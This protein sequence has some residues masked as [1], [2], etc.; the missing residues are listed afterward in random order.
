MS[1]E[2]RHWKFAM[3]RPTQC[4]SG[5]ALLALLLAGCAHPP[6]VPERPDHPFA[7]GEREASP[8]AIT[9]TEPGAN[10]VVIVIN[11]NAAFGNHAGIFAGSRLS[12]PAGS[13]AY[14]RRAEPGW[15]PRLQDYVRFQSS[16]GM[17]IRAYRFRLPAADFSA[18]LARLPE[19]DQ[20]KPLFCATAVHNSIAGIGPFS[21][22]PQSGW[23]TPAKLAELL[24]QLIIASGEGAAGACEFPNGAP[25][26]DAAPAVM[27]TRLDPATAHSS[28]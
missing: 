6:I 2:D 12:D 13:Y 27:Q 3:P 25:C 22:M 8:E 15:Q 5:L 28:Q 19:A 26:F 4:C 24:D 11:N 14:F 20:A 23:I 7:S 1:P 18:V 17:H 9:L 21:A 10:E 16:D